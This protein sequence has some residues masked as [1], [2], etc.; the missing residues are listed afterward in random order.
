MNRYPS[1]EAYKSINARIQV[2]IWRLESCDEDDALRILND[3]H[4]IL[5]VPEQ[6]HLDAAL[7]KTKPASNGVSSTL[8]GK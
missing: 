3:L 5:P 8:A 4:T 1:G 2:A 7:S 6:R